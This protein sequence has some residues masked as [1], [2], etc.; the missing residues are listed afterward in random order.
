MNLQ[1][2]KVETT[3]YYSLSVFDPPFLKAFVLIIKS[4]YNISK[5]PR[6]FFQCCLSQVVMELKIIIGFSGKRELGFLIKS[7]LCQ[8]RSKFCMQ[9]ICLSALDNV[10]YVFLLKFAWFSRYYICKKNLYLLSC[11]HVT[12]KTVISLKLQ[13]NVNFTQYTS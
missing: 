9:L 12:A 10:L 6:N 8:K 5:N 7:E 3:L 4:T 1:Q 13:P 11:Q 2:K